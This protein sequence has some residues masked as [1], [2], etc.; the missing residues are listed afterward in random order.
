ML[1]V[2]DFT[3]CYYISSK[4]LSPALEKCTNLQVLRVANTN[5][6]CNLLGKILARCPQLEHISLSVGVK[7]FWLKNSL[8]PEALDTVLPQSPVGCPWERLLKLTNFK[9]SEGTLK[10]VK[11]LEF[12]IPPD[13]VILGVILR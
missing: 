9:D 2:C 12:H 13:S 3:N 6:T 1:R 11:K 10:N 8:N 4:I 5:L 7:D